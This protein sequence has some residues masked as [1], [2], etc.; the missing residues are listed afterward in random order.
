MDE[1][2]TTWKEL[3]SVY[4]DSLLARFTSAEGVRPVRGIPRHLL[5]PLQA[6]S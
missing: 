2:Y 5:K 3:C 6:T 4:K 1:K